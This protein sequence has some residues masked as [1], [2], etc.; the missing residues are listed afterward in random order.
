MVIAVDY[1]GTKEYQHF[2]CE[3]FKI[4]VE[5]HHQHTFVFISDKPLDTS[6]A[7]SKRIFLVVLRRSQISLLSKLR[8]SSVLK[9]YKAD[10]LVTIEGLKTNVPQC[11]IA[12]DKLKSASLKRAQG[13]VTTSEFSRKKI[14][15]KFRIDE[16]KSDSYRIEVVYK[17]IDEIFTPLAFDEKEKIKEQ[18]A[19]GHEYF[20]C[21][22]KNRHGNLLDLLK[23]FSVFK[24][25]QKSN[26]QLL[27]VFD[28]LI[29]KEFSETLRLYK[30]KS[31]VKVLENI[32][33]E[34]LGKITAASYAF[35][36][37]FHNEDY[38]PLLQAIK[39]EVPVI[40][41]RA[42]QITE[43]CNDAV[44]YF[45]YSDHK[46]IGDKMMLIY[47]DENFRRQL[48][49][50]GRKQIKRYSWDKTGEELWHCIQK[51]AN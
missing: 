6:F 10:V 31:E 47:K 11:L 42:E 3:S 2:I 13:I 38:L 25:M 37:P 33:R 19:N 8:I 26:M 16:R 40:A 51:A 39:C 14:V 48:I 36:Y 34:E 4:I 7:F 43:V 44:L 22:V 15:E 50:K 29:D 1:R 5:K 17:G 23:A 35:I 9:E 18:Y 32:S 49:E 24:K 28:T 27:I 46:E 30:F 20:L 12:F 21:A 45:N 41:N